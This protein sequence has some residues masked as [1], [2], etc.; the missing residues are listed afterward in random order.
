MHR[1]SLA[2]LA[3]LMVLFVA[4]CAFYSEYYQGRQALE[5]ENYDEALRRFELAL[6]DSPDDA[7]IMTDIGIAYY[8][9]G[10]FPEA[11]HHL[12]QAKELDPKLGRT[13]LYLGLL[14]E[15]QQDFARALEEYG[16][17]TELSPLSRTGRKLKARMRMLIRKQIAEEIQ[18]AVQQEETLSVDSIPE[19]TI[20]VSYF[21]NLSGNEEFAPLQKG[22]TDM[23]IT[24]LS[25]VQSLRVVERMRLQMLMEELKLSQSDLSDVSS[26]PRL[27]KLLGARHLVNGGFVLPTESDI[28]LDALSTDVSLAETVSDV[29]VSGA[30]ERFFELEKVLALEILDDIGITLS[31]AERDAIQEI[32]TESFLAFMAYCR[33]LELEDRGMYQQ[34][35]TEFGQ[36][37]EIDPGFVEATERAEETQELIESPITGAVEET[38][39]LEQT[40]AEEEAALGEDSAGEEVVA[41][42]SDRLESLD[43]NS[44]GEFQPQAETTPTTERTAPQERDRTVNITVEW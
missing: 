25:K 41:S 32:P 21:T 9:K 27:G 13:Y 2:V 28:Q 39:Q 43:Q 8:K 16:A 33:G 22:L 10:S 4:G 15:A 1:L 23:L 26:A 7:R 38:A 5:Q 36:A 29:E 11:T 44:A 17:Y 20:A 30:L 31:Q 37:A 6:A 18:T 19:N 35:A 34:A 12:Q 42:T 40:L 24:D 14:Y 3:A